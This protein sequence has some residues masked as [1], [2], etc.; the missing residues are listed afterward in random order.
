MDKKNSNYHS[1]CEYVD[2]YESLAD[3]LPNRQDANDR[4]YVQ[5]NKRN[6]IRNEDNIVERHEKI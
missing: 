6:A 1:R 4:K 5:S 3:L 2:S